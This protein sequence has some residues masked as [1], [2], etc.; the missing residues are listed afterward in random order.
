MTPAVNMISGVIIPPI[1]YIKLLLSENPLGGAREKASRKMNTLGT[2]IQRK[3][4]NLFLRSFLSHNDSV[5][6]MIRLDHW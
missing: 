3:A 4:L 1:E 6:I 2:M 5:V